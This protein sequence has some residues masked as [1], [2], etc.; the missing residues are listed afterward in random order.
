MKKIKIYLRMLN[1]KHTFV[2]VF[3]SYVQAADSTAGN[4]TENIE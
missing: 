2:R 1:K 4:C 3:K